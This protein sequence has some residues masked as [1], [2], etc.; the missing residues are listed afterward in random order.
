[1]F[2]GE[3]S[4]WPEL[5]TGNVDDGYDI[6]VVKLNKEA[7]L[8]LPSIATQLGEFRSGKLFTALGWGLDEY[9]NETNSLRMADNLVYAKRNQC[10]EFLGDTVKEHSICAG[11]S[12]ENTCR[13]QMLLGRT[14]CQPCCGE[15]DSGGPLL[16]PN[17]SAGRIAAGNPEL[18]LLV[19]VTSMGPE[20]CN[21]TSPTIYTSIGAFWDWILWKIGEGPE[22]NCFALLF[23]VS[24]CFELGENR[25]N[26][27]KRRSR[28]EKRVH[29]PRRRSARQTRK[30]EKKSWNNRG[31]KRSANG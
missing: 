13:G 5:W 21:D 28:M 14:F 11:F 19:G 10:R 15:G 18:D 31:S 8:T 4:H 25:Q 1:M 7:N 9:G 27:V 24:D 12:N 22:V 26:P 2:S 23:L 3:E 20:D 30:R 29:E 17:R 16:I 6:A